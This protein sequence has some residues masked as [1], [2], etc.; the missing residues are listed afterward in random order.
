MPNPCD[1]ACAKI[2]GEMAGIRMGRFEVAEAKLFDS[3]N[4]LDEY[5]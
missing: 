5:A 3:A 4:R 2:G 1:R